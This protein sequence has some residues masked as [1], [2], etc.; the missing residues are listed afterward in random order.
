[1]SSRYDTV[2]DAHGHFGQFGGSFVPETLWTA[3]KE[4]E[5]EYAA[6]RKDPAFRAELADLLANEWIGLRSAKVAAVPVA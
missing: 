4:L 6:A 1:M 2:P 3:L 5:A